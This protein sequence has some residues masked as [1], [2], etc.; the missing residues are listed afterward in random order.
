MDWRESLGTPF[1]DYL[2]AQGLTEFW[3]G[4]IRAG[5]IIALLFISAF[6]LNHLG[7]SIFLK[8][9]RV[10][11][12]RTKTKVDDIFLRNKVF[13]RVSLLF[14]AIAFYVLDDLILAH[15]NTLRVFLLGAANIYV[16][17]VSAAIISALLKS[18]EHILQDTR[19][20][21]DK[22]IYSYRQV[23]SIFNYGIAT[24]LIVSILIDK[25]PMYLL[26]ALGAATAVLLLVFRDSLLGFT[27]SIQLSSNDMVRIGDWVTVD[28]YGADGDVIEINLST[29]KVQNFDKTISTVPTYAFISN[30]FKN[31][32][33]MQES[34]GRRIKRAVYINA[35]SVK[36]CSSDLIAK[37]RKVKHL[38]VF[39]DQRQKE[40]EEYNESNGVDTSVEI[41]GRRMTNLGLFRRYIENYLT[42][43]PAINHEM[44]CMVRQLQP[45]EKGLPL[46][47]YCF[48]SDKNWVNYEGIMADI[49][50]HIFA[51]TD[52]FELELFQN[53]SGRDFQKLG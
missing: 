48:S 6:I 38:S 51:S 20:F 28:A 16:I 1:Y 42:N 45:T 39:I 31:W 43:H 8:A 26:S 44:T 13:E 12:S 10:A 15:L 25:S 50:D 14:P 33:G 11:T 53:P 27:A 23:L 52:T 40:I 21:K 7:K 30:S 22:P 46:E 3:A 47:I 2:I 36:F 24:I 32:R 18:L 4:L 9:V 37:L 29:I 34:G 35:N 41:N 17:M 19:L 49:F 5:V